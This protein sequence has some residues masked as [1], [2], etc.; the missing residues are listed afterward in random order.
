MTLTSSF[1][2]FRSNSA[3]AQNNG[4]M[5]YHSVIKN[6]FFKKASWPQR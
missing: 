3:S 1:A 6:R 4:R 2:L 5:T